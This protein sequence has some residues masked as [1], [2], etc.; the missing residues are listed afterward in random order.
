MESRIQ[1][2]FLR[3]GERLASLWFAAVI[4]A[5]IAAPSWAA[6]P[7]E[8]ELE[9]LMVREVERREVEI[10]DLDSEDFEVGVFGG[11]MNVEDFGSDTVTGIRAA[12]H[13]SEDFF[14]EGVY[15]QTTLGQTSFELL[16]GGAPLLT[17]E[18][19][20]MTYYN[21]SVGWNLFPGES[22]VG[23]RW[24]FKGGLYLIAGAGSTEFGGDDRFTINAGV[25][26]RLIAT[27]WLALRIDVRDHYFESDLLGEM[28]NKHNIEF[29]GGLTIF[30]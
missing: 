9:P 5:G 6:Q 23:G 10:D 30:F 1:R 22:F 17:D 4:L 7:E 29:S 2:I 25:G 21:V 26:Y 12:Y 27:D 20:D 13:V 11:M 14:V 16:S 15:G 28:E 19:R 3:S 24:A 8:L 18:E